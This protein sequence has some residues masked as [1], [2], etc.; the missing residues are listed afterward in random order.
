MTNIRYVS[1]SL[2]LSDFAYT[3]LDQLS[4]PL[5][6]SQHHFHANALYPAL[7]MKPRSKDD[8][9]E[10]L[11]TYAHMPPSFSETFIF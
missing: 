7:V 3:V 9:K 5:L 11:I 6:S 4:G 1:G 10:E 8:P 2:L